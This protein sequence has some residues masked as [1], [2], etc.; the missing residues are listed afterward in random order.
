MGFL[1]DV[2]IE[3]LDT[4]GDHIID[5]GEFQA[6]CARGFDEM[7]TDGDGFISTKELDAL[8]GMLAKS[9][10]NALVAAASGVL[11]ASWIKTM[12]ADGDGRV[13]REEFLKGCE[14]YFDKLDSDKDHKLTRDELMALPAKMLAK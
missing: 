10:E 4:N 1:A 12:D 13:S 2:M 14:K 3:Y 6:G 5:I 9:G 8:G 11:L 7:D